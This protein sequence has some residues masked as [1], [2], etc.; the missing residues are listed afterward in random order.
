MGQGAQHEQPPLPP[1]GTPGGTWDQLCE[2]SIERECGFQGIPNVQH[3]F[4]CERTQHLIS[5][6]N[7][8]VLIPCGSVPQGTQAQ[9]VWAQGQTDVHEMKSMASGCTFQKQ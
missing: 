5:L 4:Q 8:E 3:P 6:R 2:A 9:I 1:A 7:R